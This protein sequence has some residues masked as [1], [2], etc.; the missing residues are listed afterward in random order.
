[1]A[2]YN[3]PVDKNTVATQFNVTLGP[4]ATSRQN[5]SVGGE[6][7]RRTFESFGKR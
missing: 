2:K 3:L 4:D 6:M 5:G 1:M 7:V